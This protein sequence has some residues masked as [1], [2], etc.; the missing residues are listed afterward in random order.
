M[1]TIVI[2]VLGAALMV[3]PAGAVAKPHGTDK[4]DNADKRAAIKQCKAERG[5]SKATRKAFKAKYHSFS[6]CVRQNAAEEHA[7][8]KAALRNA[9][10]ECKAERADANFPATH[11]GKSFAE[12]Y[13]TGK[14]GKNAFGKCVSQKAHEK[15]EA[16]DQTDQ[17]EVQAF[18]N[19]AKQCAG[20]RSDSG[21]PA[22]HGGK[23]FDEFY[24]TNHNTRTAFGKCVSSHSQTY[25]DPLSS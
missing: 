9:A 25:V 20:E 10:K 2:A 23:T 7:E 22:A 15:K 1:K 11:D 12:F 8:K 21:F 6:R 19:A 17:Q 18:K 13:G 14:R 4:P 16:E 5:K 24:G 3:L